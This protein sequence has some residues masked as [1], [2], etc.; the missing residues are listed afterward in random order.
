MRA[1]ASFNPPVVFHQSRDAAELA[2]EQMHELVL[3]GL[4]TRQSD[5]RRGRR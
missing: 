5:R 2:L 1:Y 3:Q 4:L